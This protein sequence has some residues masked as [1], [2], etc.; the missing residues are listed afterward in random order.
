MPAN[1]VKVD[2]TTPWGNPFIV[3]EDDTRERCLALF[4]YLVSGKLCISASDAC[5]ER[6]RAFM[7][8]AK[9]ALAT[10]KGRDLACWCPPTERCHAD[11]LLALANPRNAV[12]RRA[13][14]A[15]QIPP[16]SRV[17]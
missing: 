10:L 14:M 17:G 15:W 7:A 3:G 1:A 5:L 9:P 11:V 8:H 13:V 4:V 12:L 2:R 6:Q 16:L